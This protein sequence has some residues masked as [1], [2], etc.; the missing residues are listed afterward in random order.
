M[1]A[2]E[3]LCNPE[4]VEIVVKEGPERIQEIIDW[5]AQF[6]KDAEGDSN[7][8]KKAA[9]LNSGFFIIKMLREKKLNV[10]Y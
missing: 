10:H 8:V 1:I 4:I 7:S 6:D 5:G 9:I 2:G 3:G